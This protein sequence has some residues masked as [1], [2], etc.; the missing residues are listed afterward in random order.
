MRGISRPWKGG[1]R[2][3]A[4]APAR[5]AIPK[6][7]DLAPVEWQ[8]R[9]ACFFEMIQKRRQAQLDNAS[10]GVTQ[11]LGSAVETLNHLMIQANGD[12]LGFRHAV[13]VSTTSVIIKKVLR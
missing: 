11:S 7:G 9:R 1:S 2:L 3:A 13:T 8:R 6:R 10:P 12:G 4:A 5:P